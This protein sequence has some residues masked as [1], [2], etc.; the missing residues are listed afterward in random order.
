[1]KKQINNYV[2]IIF[3]TTTLAFSIPSC[4]TKAKAENLSDSETLQTEELSLSNNEE[5]KSVENA[6]SVVQQKPTLPEPTVE[7]PTLP[8]EKAKLP[9]VVKLDEMIMDDAWL[10][11]SYNLVYEEIQLLEEKSKT[12]LSG[13]NEDQIK[14]IMLMTNAVYHF[15]D[16][17]VP[18]AKLSMEKFTKKYK[19]DADFSDLFYETYYAAEKEIN[20]DILSDDS[21]GITDSGKRR[22]VY[23]HFTNG[24]RSSRSSELQSMRE[25]LIKGQELSENVI[26][27]VIS[28]ANVG[29]M[30]ADYKKGKELAEVMNGTINKLNLVKALNPN[31][32]D[33]KSALQKVEEKRKSRLEEIHNSLVEYRFPKRFDGA[34]RPSNYS[35]LE[36]KMKR[37]LENSNRNSSSKYDVTS[38]H[39]ASQWI[40]IVHVLSGRHLY[41]QIDFYVAVPSL[42]N[43]DVLEVLFVTGKTGGPHHDSFATYSVG[44]IGQMLKENL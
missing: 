19:D 24:Y 40:D 13:T 41:S 15:N 34:S 30:V 37:F 25:L 3:A 42:E 5:V 28:T 11:A 44:G 6:N 4:G 18:I 31:H 21:K 12:S 26:Q 17:A 20:G 38:I 16:F 22:E 7:L 23:S 1:M 14:A 29:M 35:S 32:T 39:I 33:L 10:E 2:A 43:K 36:D 9:S 8:Y 27:Q